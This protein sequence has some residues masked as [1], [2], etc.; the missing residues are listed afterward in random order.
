MIRGQI[1]SGSFKKTDVDENFLLL[2]ERKT[3]NH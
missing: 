1:L 3:R 2:R